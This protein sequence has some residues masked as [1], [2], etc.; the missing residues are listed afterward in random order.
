MQVVESEQD[1]AGVEYRCLD[2]ELLPLTHHLK[3][4]TA[5]QILE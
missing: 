5:W 3:E 2:I 1:L 4:F